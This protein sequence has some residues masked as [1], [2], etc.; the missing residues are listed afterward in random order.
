MSKI[1]LVRR[2]KPCGVFRHGSSVLGLSSVPTLAGAARVGLG[3]EFLQSLE[4]GPSSSLRRTCFVKEAGRLS[5]GP[6]ALAV[7]HLP[8]GVFPRHRLRGR[9]AVRA[10]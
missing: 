5:L 10:S 4:L 3:L 1:A 6:L 2:T 7:I 8:L 9:R